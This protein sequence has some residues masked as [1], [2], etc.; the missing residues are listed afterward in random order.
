[1]FCNPCFVTYKDNGKVKKKS[2]FT[3]PV[4]KTLNLCDYVFLKR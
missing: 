3:D 1:M 2:L 4:L